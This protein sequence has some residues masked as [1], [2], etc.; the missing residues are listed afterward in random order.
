M[1]RGL[2]LGKFLPPHTGHLYLLEF[3]RNFC[4][5]LTVVVGTLASEP[6]DGALRHAWMRELCPGAKV[7]HLTDENPQSPEQHPEF[8]AIW[9]ASLR[10]IL[11]QPPDLVF[12]SERYGERLAHEL[13]A[14]FVIVDPARCAVP[15]SGTAVRANPLAHFDHLPLC[16]RAHYALRV[17]IFGPESTGKSTLAAQLAEHYRTQW[18]PEYARAFL[19]HRAGDVRAEDMV[20]IARGQGAAEDALARAANRILFCDTDP[21]ATQIWSAALFDQVPDAVT[22]AA[23]GRVYD[24]TLL[25]DTDVPWVADSVRYLPEDRA[26]FFGECQRALRAAGR[27]VVALRGNFERR[28]ALARAAVD[29]LLRERGV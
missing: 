17:S 3:A 28:F 18:V 23:Q 15:V 7:L 16:V 11:P 29:A 19:E 25:L 12:A 10:R 21:L 1:K 2:V 6:I 4:S 8:W 26:R 5:D 20:T 9:R 13:E 27:N 22:Q 24:L 14:R